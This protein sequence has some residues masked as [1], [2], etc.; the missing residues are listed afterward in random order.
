VSGYVTET[1]TVT[2]TISAAEGGNVVA[3]PSSLSYAYTLGGSAPVAT[4]LSITSAAGNSSATPYTISTSVASPRGGNWLLVGSSPSTAI[5]NGTSET[6]PTTLYVGVNTAGLSAGVY[7]GAITLTPTGGTVLTIPVTLTVN[8]AAIPV[9]T[10]S[11][12][13]VSF[14]Y[15]QGTYP[16]A[17]Q[18]IQVN[19]KTGATVNFTATASSIPSGW[20]LVSPANGSTST[21]IAASV[22]SSALASLAPGIYS[23]SI[24][25]TPS[26]AGSSA[27]TVPVTLSVVATPVTISPSTLSFTYAGGSLPA[28]QSFQVSAA[29]GAALSFTAQSGNPDWLSVTPTSGTTPA[30]VNV[31]VSPASLAAG[32][33]SGSV[34]ITAGAGTTPSWVPVSL[35]VGAGATISSDIPSMSFAYQTGS[36]SLPTASTVVRASGGAAVSVTATTSASWLSV[37]PVSGTTPWYLVVSANPAGLAAGN[38]SANVILTAS[39]AGNP[40]T[41]VP[42]TLTV[43]ATPTVVPVPAS[44][45]FAYQIGG[46]TPAAQ[47][48]QLSASNGSALA[49]TAV[50]SSSGNWLS[51]GPASAGTPSTLVVSVNTAGLAA[52]NYSGTV[53]LT[54]NSTGN[55]QTAIPVSLTVTAATTLAAS[56]E[57][58]NFS[59][60]IGGSLPPSQSIQL[61]ASSNGAVSFTAATSANWLSVAPTS[62]ATPATLVVSVSPA[63]LAAGPYSGTVTVNAVASIAISLT[64]TASSAPPVSVVS[65]VLNAASYANSAVSPGE[66]VSIFGTSIGPANSAYLTLD[67]TGKVATS[68]DG[69]TVSIGG[70]LAPLTYAGSGQINAIVPYEVAGNASPSVQVTY[71]G[72][73]LDG[74]SL[75]VAATAPAIF[76]QNGSGTGPGAILNQDYSLNTLSNPAPAGSVVQIYMTGEG[77]TTPAQAD[78]TVTPVNTSGVGPITPAP[79][80][81]ITVS[82]GGQ[83]AQVDFAGEAPGDVAGVLQVDAEV[84]AAAGSGANSIVVRIGNATSQSGVTVWVK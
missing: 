14:T 43:T 37:T 69:V 40:Q 3:S 79:Q 17:A 46:S 22:A 61:S 81:A 21:S 6:T 25:I 78:G 26:A 39:I 47:S 12:S 24:V 48:V 7:T 42:V 20:L 15:Q 73:T 59:Y 51:A 4:E 65:A 53:A 19:E 11:P 9:L 35:N 16:P 68:L 13:S 54:A 31:S 74:P 41:L 50:A 45:S 28:S 75:Q 34:I 29:G 77:L 71:G 49:F 58:L 44:L 62:G 56:P 1:L 36:A 72:Q 5:P 18:W 30:T 64:V 76:T 83:P 27:V 82:I 38:Y 70:Y 66:M 55:A 10:A 57:A 60:Q 2:L 23:G 32:V 67:A 84:P 8:A 80:A 33:Y 52:G 63:G